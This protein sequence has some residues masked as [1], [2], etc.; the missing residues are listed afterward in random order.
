MG[1]EKSLALDFSASILLREKNAS[2]LQP[3]DQVNV[4]I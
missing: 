2:S 3:V 4:T 1:A